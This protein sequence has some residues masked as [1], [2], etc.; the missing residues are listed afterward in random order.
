MGGRELRGE[1]ALV[2]IFPLPHQHRS[3]RPRLRALSGG[4]LPKSF[5]KSFTSHTPS[6]PFTIS[7]PVSFPRK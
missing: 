4:L 1:V 6:Q 2:H 5:S 7:L 3:L